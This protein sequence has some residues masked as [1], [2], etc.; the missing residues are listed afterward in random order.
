MLS[1]FVSLAQSLFGCAE[2]VIAYLLP[3]GSVLGISFGGEVQ[4]ARIGDVLHLHLDCLPCLF[5]GNCSVKHAVSC[6]G[7]LP[8]TCRS[9]M[10]QDN[11]CYRF[12]REE[13]AFYAIQNHVCYKPFALQA[14][15]RCFCL[16][17]FGE[18]RQL[19][20]WCDCR[21]CPL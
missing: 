8:Y 16:D 2:I 18:E 1:A 21:F 7:E 14:L 20:C 13:R 4:D 6:D 10:L 5:G 3:W 12:S 17:A 19:V 15:A 9:V 11:I